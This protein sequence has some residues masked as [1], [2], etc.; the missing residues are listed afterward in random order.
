MTSNESESP[1]TLS[2]IVNQFFQGLE[3]EPNMLIVRIASPFEFREL[4]SQI[5]V[6][7]GHLVCSFLLASGRRRERI[8]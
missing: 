4:A 2:R 7:G 3:D 6:C 5:R 8:S 1:S